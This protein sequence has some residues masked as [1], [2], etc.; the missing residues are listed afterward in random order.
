V[1][2]HV[3][4]GSSLERESI[5]SRAQLM[6]AEQ[7]L[8]T[9]ALQLADLKL[10]LNDLRGLPLTTV[11]DL[12]PAPAESQETCPLEESIM[13][14]TASHPEFLEARAEVE[15][16]EAAVRLT[17]VENLAYRLFEKNTR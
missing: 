1:S 4:F 9:T 15:Q 17:D 5:E 6:Q 10:K 2:A 16:A 12:D 11:L 14:A 13:T 7:D 3:K 8:R